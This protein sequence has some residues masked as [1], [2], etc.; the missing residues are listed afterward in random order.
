[1]KDMNI[2]DCK[3]TGCPNLSESNSQL[4]WM[5][6][7]LSFVRGRHINGCEPRPVELPGGNWNRS[8][9]PVGVLMGYL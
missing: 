6:E 3:V 7:A 5:P 8:A 9:D 4:F 1:M 2:K